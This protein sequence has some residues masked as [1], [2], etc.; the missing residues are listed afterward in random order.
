[1]GDVITTMSTEAARSIIL[2][3]LNAERAELTLQIEQLNAKLAGIDHVLELTESVLLPREPST[4]KI[5]AFP[6]LTMTPV[7]VYSQISN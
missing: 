5:L 4:A 7:D 2:A 1:M 3:D 6:A